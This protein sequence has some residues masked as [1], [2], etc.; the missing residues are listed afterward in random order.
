VSIDE[1]MRM[2]AL[3]LAGLSAEACA[4][5]ACGP[6]DVNRNGRITVD[7]IIGAVA[8]ALSGCPGG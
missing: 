4:P 3:A 6:A 7:E 8:V 2:V 1:L 5:D